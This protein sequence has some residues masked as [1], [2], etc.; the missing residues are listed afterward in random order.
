MA[1]TFLVFSAAGT[2][3]YVYEGGDTALLIIG[4]LKS[5]HPSNDKSLYSYPRSVPVA[6]HSIKAH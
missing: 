2:E 3:N 5:P 4:S 6:S 1:V